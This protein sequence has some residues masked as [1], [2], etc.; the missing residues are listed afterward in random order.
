MSTM[1][2]IEFLEAFKGLFGNF[3][4]TQCD[5]DNIEVYDTKNIFNYID[6]IEK[7]IL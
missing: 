6:L 4:P 7:S 5:I 3:Q 1:A 2:D